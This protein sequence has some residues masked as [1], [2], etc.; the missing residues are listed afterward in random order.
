MDVAELDLERG[1]DL[2]KKDSRSGGLKKTK[3]FYMMFSQ[4]PLFPEIL[5]II[6]RNFFFRMRP[7]PTF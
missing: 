1:N 5:S 3:T 6:Y 2:K 7:Y 4:P